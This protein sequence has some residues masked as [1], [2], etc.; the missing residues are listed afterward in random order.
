MASLHETAYPRI[1]PDLDAREL[2]GVFS[3]TKPEL[4]F[5]EK[6]TR[7]ATVS[8][9]G[10]LLYLKLVQRLGYFPLLDD[11]PKTIARHIAH[12]AGLKRLPAS[13]IFQEYQSSGA[14]RRHVQLVREFLGIRLLKSDSMP[15]LVNIA[16]S[17]AETLDAESDIV[18]VMLEELVR[19]KFELPAFSTL[20]R[21]AQRARSVVNQGYFEQLAS[22]L[23][24][25]NKASID[26]LLSL[27]GSGPNTNWNS[28]KSQPK[29]PTNKRVRQYLHHIHWMETLTQS[30]P[31][32]T[33][34]PVAKRR[35]FLLEARALD[36]G[37]MRKLRGPKR[38][39]LAL[40]F[41]HSQFRKSLDD[42]AD[43]LIRIVR[44]MENTA[45]KH[46][47]QHR[48][49][50]ADQVDRLVDQLK[51]MLDALEGKGTAK[52][53][54]EKVEGSLTS[55]AETLRTQ[56]EEHLAYSNNNALPFLLGPYRAKRSLCFN[57]L[58][59]LKLRSAS[60]DRSS[61][62]WLKCLRA[63]KDLRQ[64]R[65]AF[66]T[67]GVESAE[68]LGWLPERWR[69]LVLDGPE[70]SES[71][72][73][74]VHRKY[75]E[76]ALFSVIKRELSSG[77]LYVEQGDRFDDY[78]EQLVDQETFDAE[79]ANYCE[80]VELDSDPATFTRHCRD[81]L[82]SAAEETDKAF[83]N[84]QYASMVKGRLVMSRPKTLPIKAAQR[85]LDKELTPR[86]PPTSLLDAL[87][88]TE[89][90]L[91]LH[92]LFK[93]LSGQSTRVDDARARFVAT[94]FCY[95]CNLGPQQTARSV[96]EFNRRQIAWLNLK[97]VSEERLDQA[98]VEVIN[99]YNK[100]EL[101]SYWGTGK[102]VAA[103][104]TKWNLYEQN[105]LSEYHIRYGGYGGIGY[106]HVSDKYIALFSHFIPCGVH[107][108]VYILDGLIAN[109]SD[110]QPDTV[111]GD[112]HAQSYPVFALAHLLG[113]K[114]MPRIRGIKDLSFFRPDKESLYQ[115][116]DGLF[117]EPINEKI[118]ESHYHE[119]LRI[120][121][122][123]RMGTITPSAILRRLGTYN[124]KNKLYFA[125]RELG[126]V[127]RT[128][129]LLRYISDVELRQVVH[130][131]TNKNEEFNDFVKWSFFGGEGIIAENVRHEQ[132][133]II[134]YNHLVANML[135]LHNVEQMSR[136]L[137]TLR[138]EG[139][140]I[141]KE[142][143][144]GLA[145]YR[146]SHINRFGDYTLDLDRVVEPLSANVG[147]L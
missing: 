123:I 37:E 57:C 31:P 97:H 79:L 131:A 43:L 11:V 2:A 115:H 130:A 110:I 91:D 114:L 137:R 90:W 125:F 99:A 14:K 69:R 72:Q 142:L 61:E 63:L 101:P 50:Q 136:V 34:I 119:M 15:W 117:R 113:V 121:V 60:D 1:N 24:P 70:G 84:N 108:A 120:A 53:R 141:D 140:P 76:L 49:T 89:K 64:V 42:A 45:R 81:W 9:L 65:V 23:N 12:A 96:K 55:D 74:T 86:L 100:F 30:L 135:I 59:I 144:A 16:E 35:Q 62:I 46:L 94:L 98:T 107:E 92:R 39:A 93:P 75:L 87:I 126:R 17:A 68:E 10:L 58:E 25:E 28:L 112:T 4:D 20:Q 67:I 111:H 105:L 82:A 29:R 18:N 85:Q 143:L 103:D 13:R 73:D 77:D 127:I 78:R 6:Y 134:K 95:G 33:T 104:G 118:I 132:R 116:I 145:P 54:L 48:I 147:I 128:V 88:D 106:Y 22:T 27:Q 138:Q 129:Y 56:C 146:R 19:A 36:A 38:Y 7:R 66:S 124:R 109:Q 52:Q 133:K 71:E 102:H 5:V 3:P 8:R 41:I 122:S 26:E 139:Q 51:R 47:D 32:A 80:V 21:R 40:L 83:P 44:V